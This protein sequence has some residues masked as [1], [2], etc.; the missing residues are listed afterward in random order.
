MA[1]SLA[2][3]VWS[4]LVS[5]PETKSL[6]GPI[7]PFP[8]TYAETEPKRLME[9]KA[10]S[11]SLL[12]KG[13]YG[14]NAA[15]FSPD[16]GRTYIPLEGNLT[17]Q[18]M[19]AF[20]AYWYVATRWR[21][22][23]IAEAP[24]MVVEES[25]DDGSDEWLPDHE[26]AGVLD[27]P[28][29][30]YDMGELLETTS[31][32][33]DNSGAALWV[34]DTD[35]VGTPARITPFNRWQFEPRSDGTRLFSS[36]KVQTRNG[37]E[38]FPADRC[39]FF[40]DFSGQTWDW[41]M[42][43]SRLD[44]ALSWLRLGAMA[45]KTIHDLLGNAIWPSAVIVPDKDW[46]PDAKVLAEY[47]QDIEAYAHSGNKGRPFIMLGGGSFVPLQSS[48]KDLV[49]DE[50]LNRVESVVA[51]VSGVPAIVLQFEVGL[52]NSPWSQMAQARR[53][54]YD[55]TIVPAWKKI[56]RVLTR[57]MLRPVDEDESHYIRFDSSKVPALQDDKQVAV[58]I[59]V[60]MGRAASLN[61]RR[62]QMGLE[63]VSDPKADEIP[64]LT[65]PSLQDILAGNAGGNDAENDQEDSAPDEED[66][67]DAPPSKDPKDKEKK[68]FVL[69]RKFQTPA[70]QQAFRQEAIHT[71]QTTSLILLHKDAEHIAEIV[72]TML[73]EPTSTKG[74]QMDIKSRGKE[75][76]M[77]AVT[78][79]LRGTSR[80]QWAKATTPL[81]VQASERSTAVIAADLNI[82][83]S[84]L[85]KNVVAFASKE[86]GLLVSSV[87]NTTKDIVNNIIQGG[88]DEGATSAQ[89][90]RLIRESTGLGKSR[91]DLIARTETTRAYNGAPTESLKALGEATGR[92]FTKTWSGVLDDKERDEHVAMEG[93]TVGIDETFSNGLQFPSE[94]NCRCTVTYSEVDDE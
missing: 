61:E 23:K 87:S 79:Y 85:H 91:S 57:Q 60:M 22:Q 19:L 2:R 34:F 90:S 76:V 59:A 64:E 83:F 21:A 11:L 53:M 15:F 55:D 49:P 70:L 43:R 38:E 46:N 29:D 31:H 44:H 51:A 40:R 66:P 33:L 78:G 56:E 80:Q 47:K 58:S 89:I 25:E 73:L 52:Q 16:G 84:L 68:R 75:R 12:P 37:Q 67:E 36:F 62:K 1:P 26:L 13:A 20:V 30:D 3:R 41:T 5:G 7:Q 8:K 81:L 82:S 24:L 9:E 50:V 17:G 92:I 6:S 18:S 72:D 74:K 42:G 65:Q 35:G 93:E 86:A 54:A 14:V 39:A 69:D 10:S 77:S 45:T 88:L 32:Y 63:P 28:S 94:P 71:W 4:A 48:I 27:Q